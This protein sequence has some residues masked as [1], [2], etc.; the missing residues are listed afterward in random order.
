MLMGVQLVKGKPTGDVA[1]VQQAD[2]V[3]APHDG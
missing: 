2:D 1:S 3:F